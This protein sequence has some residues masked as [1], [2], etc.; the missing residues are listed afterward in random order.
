MTAPLVTFHNVTIGYPGH[1][2]LRDINLDVFPGQ[3]VAVLGPNGSGKTAFLKTVAGILRPLAGEVRLH[4][5]TDGRGGGVGYVPQ[6]AT[7]SNL[8]PLTVYEVVEMGTY[9]SV[10]PWRRL[11]TRAKERID[12][13][14]EEVSVTQLAGRAYA[15]L[16]GGQQQRVLI[17][18][19]LAS[20]PAI[21]VMDEPLAS[22]DRDSVQSMVVL[23]A[24]LRSEEHLTMLWADHFVP[25]LREV[26]R[27]V[28]LIEDS[29]LIWSRIDELLDRER[30]LLAPN[31][32]AQS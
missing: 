24:R 19:A 5:L 14:L 17:A 26:V 27:E 20:N 1:P 29:R 15:D 13:A 9:Q 28:M 22:L 12:W 30:K 6:R 2:V 32:A 10:K 31:E 4:T 7:V 8:L 3:S 21:L 18:R 16:S 23:L 25:A 11:G